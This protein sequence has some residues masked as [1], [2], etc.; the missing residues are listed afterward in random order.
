MHSYRRYRGTCERFDSRLGFGFLLTSDG[1]RVFVGR[2]ML[3]RCGVGRQLNPGDIVE[4]A[5]A[6]G[7]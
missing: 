5:V 4:F 1:R 6:M 3:E 2:R 7:E